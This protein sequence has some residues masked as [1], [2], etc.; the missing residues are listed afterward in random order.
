MHILIVCV[1]SYQTL[2]SSVAEQVRNRL[3][4]RTQPS[5]TEPHSWEHLAAWAC[6]WMKS[7]N[8]FVRTKSGSNS[9]AQPM[10]DLCTEM[11][12][13]DSFT[14]CSTVVQHLKARA[15]RHTQ[16][17]S[18]KARALCNS[19][20]RNLPPPRPSCRFAPPVTSQYHDAW[21]FL[22]FFENTT[23]GTFFEMG[24]EDGLTGSLSYFFERSLRWTGILVEP[25]P[26]TFRMLLKNRP[27]ARSLK[28]NKCVHP[29]HRWVEFRA[30]GPMGGIV[31]SSA[32]GNW[33]AAR[34]ADAGGNQT[35]LKEKTVN[36][37]F[38]NAP[39]NVSCVTLDE[40]LQSHVQLREHGVDWFSLD[41]EGFELPVL[42]SFSW[43]VPLHVL[44]IENNV[45]SRKIDRLLSS[46]GF[47]YFA[48][49]QTN[50][51]WVNCSWWKRCHMSAVGP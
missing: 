12:G 19:K 42:Q 26:R 29:I 46:K 23:R 18:K 36:L 34:N 14:T 11:T 25:Q 10:F 1:W 39:V 17:I 3:P 4:K 48:D 28:V 37:H 8:D 30:N 33:L 9:W 31:D 5:P 47:Q 51:I 43:T 44:T 45:H 15:G 22:N 7:E 13:C 41:V 38:R 50:S 20:Y 40:I 24:A 35:W 27:G 49:Y 21:A 16:Q 6:E 32:E 2:V